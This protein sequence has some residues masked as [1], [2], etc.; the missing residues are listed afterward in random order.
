MAKRGVL[1]WAQM[2]INVKKVASEMELNGVR[3][4]LGRLNM[5]GKILDETEAE[6]EA[7]VYNIAR[8][9]FNLRSPK[10]LQKILRLVFPVWVESEDDPGSQR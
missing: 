5:L 2:E 3:V 9:E 7:K 6:F 10:Q 4:D 8:Q 1:Q